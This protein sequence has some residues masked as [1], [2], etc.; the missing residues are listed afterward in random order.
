MNFLKKLVLSISVL[1]FVNIASAGYDPVTGRF[2][3]QDPLGRG[4]RI[5]H[6]SH[7]PQWVGTNG[8]QVSDPRPVAPNPM[9]GLGNI[10]SNPNMDYA[11]AQMN[12][13]GRPNIHPQVAA[14]QRY[15]SL[16]SRVQTAV[17]S[18]HDAQSQLQTGRWLAQKQLVMPEDQYLDGMNLYQYCIS[19]PVSYVD[20]YGLKSKQCQCGPDVTGPLSRFKAQVTS[21]T[22]HFH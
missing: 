12:S 3:Q 22:V 1:A 21:C 19:N 14:Q 2:H 17:I 10:G 9:A 5:V 7:G 11:I 4:P 16:K 6:T 8:P 20:P 18:V 15:A 13:V